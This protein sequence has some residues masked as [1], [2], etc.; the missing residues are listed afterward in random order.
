MELHEL[1]AKANY[2]LG[3]ATG[4]EKTGQERDAITALAELRDLLNDQP[5]LEAG[6]ATETPPPER[7][8]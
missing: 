7:T 5:E 2:V 3:K 4:A 1:I 6:R 8:Q